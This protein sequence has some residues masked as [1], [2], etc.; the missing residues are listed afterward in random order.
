[1]VLKLK[2][3]GVSVDKG[4]IPPLYKG[5]GFKLNTFGVSVDKGLIPPKNYFKFKLTTCGVST[6]FAGDCITLIDI[7]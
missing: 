2:T 7:K 4:I 5:F 1:M 6:D 3:F